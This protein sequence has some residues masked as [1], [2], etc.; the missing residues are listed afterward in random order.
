[1]WAWGVTQL[2]VTVFTLGIGD[3]WSV[4]DGIV[5]LAGN[6]RRVPTAAA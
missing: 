6:P 4:I 2:L 3:I 5:I 1:M